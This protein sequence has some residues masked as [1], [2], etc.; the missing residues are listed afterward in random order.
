MRVL[1]YR[2]AV[3]I[4]QCFDTGGDIDAVAEY[5]VALDNDI[6]E[7]NADA[8]AYGVG[9]CDVGVAGE[10]VTSAVLCLSMCCIVITWCIDRREA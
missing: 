5:I 7:M 4:G 6:A 2:N 9:V 3:R 8:K 1:G 10:S